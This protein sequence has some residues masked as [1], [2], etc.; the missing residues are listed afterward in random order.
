M[1]SVLLGE[2]IF[3]EELIRSNGGHVEEVA[4]ASDD[5]HDVGRAEVEDFVYDGVVHVLVDK[6]NCASHVHTFQARVEHRVG[7]LDE[8]LEPHSLFPRCP[9]AVVDRHVILVGCEV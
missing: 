1:L 4:V 9:Q 5:A 8:L 2:S 6:R 7:V 3:G